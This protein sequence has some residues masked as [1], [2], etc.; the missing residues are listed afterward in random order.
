MQTPSLTPQLFLA[1]ASPRRQE[2]LTQ[3]GVAHF[4][5]RLPPVEGADEPRLANETPLAYVQRTALDKAHRASE[6]LSLPQQAATAA[7]IAG[8]PILAADTTVALG[9][10]ILGKPTDA[11]D[12]ASILMQLSDQTHTVFTAV[13]VSVNGAIYTALS[14]SLVRFKALSEAEIA[15]Y[16][17]SGECFGKA[18][19]YGIQG[20]AAG[21]IRDLRG[22]YS[23]VMGLPLYETTELLKT[24]KIL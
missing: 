16:I 19:A 12:A 11:K 4:V 24:I 20:L 7:L 2:L 17:Q 6:W 23:G 10:A 21:F 22:S 5:L 13:V 8:Q 9:D 15:S 1:S 3:I 18:G 14:E